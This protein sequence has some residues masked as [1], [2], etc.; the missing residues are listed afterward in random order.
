MARAPRRAAPGFTL[1]E[2]LVGLAVG[3][4]LSAAAIAVVVSSSR[5][6]RDLSEAGIQAENAGYA[7]RLLR[8]E[9]S[10][11]G[12]YGTWGWE[13]P[14]PGD[15]GY[16]TLPDF[17]ATTWNSGTSDDLDNALYFYV[18]G[19]VDNDDLSCLAD[20]DYQDGTDILI[21]RRAETRD[22]GDLIARDDLDDHEDQLFVQGAGDEG[23]YERAADT[24]SENQTRF[25]L[26]KEPF[27]DDNDSSTPEIVL[28]ADVRQVFFQAYFIRPYSREDASG[29]PADSIPTLTRMVIDEVGGPLQVEPLVEGIENMRFQYGLDCFDNKD[30]TDPT[31]CKN[32]RTAGIPNEWRSAD[33]ITAVADWGRVVAVR[34][35]LLA[36][37]LNTSHGYDDNKTYVLGDDNVTPGGEFRRHV[38]SSTVRLINPSLRNK[39][40]T[41]Y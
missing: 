31:S 13:V 2:I 33:E 24:D 16:D 6:A 3:I 8:D 12:F 26:T 1:V 23:I 36:R 37:N 21:V 15:S 38:Y 39:Y 17:C 10:H 14:R 20:D 22:P 25:N 32:L 41:P 28:P 7:M 27:D 11:A 40:D 30:D 34:V 5:T 29:N 4:I 19:Y 18:Q 35:H 9:I